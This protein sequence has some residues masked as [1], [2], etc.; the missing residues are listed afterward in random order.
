[1]QAQE[2]RL[3][4]CQVAAPWERPFEAGHIKSMELVVLASLDWRIVAL[5]PASF[6]DRF[7][8][9]L[10]AA[11]HLRGGPGLLQR[12]RC[13]TSSLVARTL[14]G[15][16]TH[17]TLLPRQQEPT[18]FDLNSSLVWPETSQRRPAGGGFAGRLHSNETEW[19]ATD[20]L[21]PA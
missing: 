17:R 8:A 7:L 19:I 20:R 14:P 11:G 15:P 6:L 16:P 5:T 12:L 2:G 4:W 10:A 9:A 18:L 21:K 1:M 13:R 3:T